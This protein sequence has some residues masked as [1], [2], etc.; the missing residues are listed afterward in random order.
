MTKDWLMFAVAALV[1]TSVNSAEPQSIPWNVLYSAKE[2]G[3]MVHETDAQDSAPLRVK[4]IFELAR[5]SAAADGNINFLGFFVGMSKYDA[6][7]LVKYYK[8]TESECS[9]NVSEENAVWY[10]H[11]SLKA[12][13]R[14]TNGGNT[15]RELGQAVANHVG[16]MEGYHQPFLGRKWFERKT[17]DGVLILFE[18]PAGLTMTQ[19]DAISRN[20]IETSYARDKR[21][22]EEEKKKEFKRGEIK[23]PPKIPPPVKLPPG[24]GTSRDKPLSQAEIMKA[25]AAGRKFGASNQLVANE[26]QRCVSLITR[27][28]YECWTDFNWSENL[29]PVL[30]TVKFGGGGKILGYRIVQSSGDAKVDESVLSAAKRADHVSG[31][32]ADFLKRYPEVTISMTPKRL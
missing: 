3:D 14:L 20:P 23:K 18:D 16:D 30:L 21:M 1:A 15:F 17:I 10:I 7:E 11:F 29:R 27:R 5:T 28:F 12:V 19:E 22:V 31:L 2:T 13:R 9:F 32:S 26:E 25:L 24:K 6:E 4:R 8:L